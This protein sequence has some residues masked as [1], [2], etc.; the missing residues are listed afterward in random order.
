MTAFGAPRSNEKDRQEAKTLIDAAD[1]AMDLRRDPTEPFVLE[2]HFKA[3]HFGEGAY[4]LEWNRR[5]KWR[6]TITLKKSTQTK[7]RNGDQLWVQRDAAVSQELFNEIVRVLA[8]T[9]S[10]AAKEPWI[11]GV[12]SASADGRSMKCVTVSR[13]NLR[14]DECVDAAT[15]LFVRRQYPERHQDVEFNDYILLG[16]KHFPGSIRSTNDRLSFELQVDSLK[17]AKLKDSQFAGINGV[18]PWA[19]CDNMEM[20]TPVDAP[21]PSYTKEA[22][23]QRTQGTV[24]L[25]I[26]VGSD[27]RVHDS[28]IIRR[29]DAGLDQ[30]AMAAVK[31]WKFKPAQCGDRYVPAE[32][33]V[34]VEFHLY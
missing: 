27:G 10:F 17:E 29:L 15:G 6:E 24:V 2:A 21:D 13:S 1:D 33:A 28:A 8:L 4:R 19:T 16:T 11:E 26:S 20:P 23:V 3:K 22:R 25:M 5:D 18:R 32:L 34:E 9:P 7:I 12:K 30:Q 31:N 14:E